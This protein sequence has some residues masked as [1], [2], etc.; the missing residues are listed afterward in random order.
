LVGLR[1][2]V[3]LLLKTYESTPVL[4]I[5]FDMVS[6]AFVLQTYL[7]KSAIELI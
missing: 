3:A 2:L 6:R 5:L 7:T 4:R 1:I